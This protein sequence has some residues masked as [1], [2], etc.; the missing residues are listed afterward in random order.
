MR[1]IFSLCALIA[2]FMLIAVIG[3]TQNTQN[4]QN[5]VSPTPLRANE[6]VDIN[7]TGLGCTDL[8]AGQTI[9]AGEVCIDDVDTNG[10]NEV[11][12]ITVTYNTSGG[13]E[14]TEVHLWIGT[15]T[16][17]MPA[18][19]T[20]NPIPGQFP[21]SS[22]DITGAT[23]YTFTIPFTAFGYDCD[24]DPQ[25]TLY[26]AAH[27]AL[28]K[29]NAD[30]SWQTQTGW[31]NGQRIVAKGNW[32][33]RFS[34]TI[35]CDEYEPPVYGDSETAWAY[36][37]TYALCF[38]NLDC[39]VNNKW[40]WTNGPL[41]AYSYSFD[42]LAGAAQC[43][44]SKGAL[45]GTVTINYTGTTAT[46]VYTMK[47]GWTLGETHLYI[48]TDP[49]ERVWV[50]AKGDPDKPNYEPAHWE[51]TVEPGQ[52]TYKHENLN[53]ATSDTYTASE[54]GNLSGDIYV[55]AHAQVFPILN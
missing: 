18:T 53:Y 15:A 37:G 46:V 16:S 43:D 48:G 35:S 49:L 28:R 36:G 7:G 17:Q 27:A 29:L 8:L 31:G 30:G 45:A 10:D 11:D 22:G 41:A 19:R 20:G 4:S 3:C 44:T 6:V 24:A 42:L 47:P 38:L 14:L 34:F 32:A 9:I 26:G 13:W 50:E 23:T 5:P 39:V 25:P 21:Y 55:A 12:A 1:N 40:G 2:L 54:I 52:L 33:T 51:C